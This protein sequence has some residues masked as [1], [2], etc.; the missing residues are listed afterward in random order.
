MF[1]V[2]R[3]RK[4]RKGKLAK[5]A[6]KSDIKFRNGSRCVDLSLRPLR[7]FSLHPLRLIFAVLYY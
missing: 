4:G 2:R 1:D 7:I 5:D 6:K 3:N